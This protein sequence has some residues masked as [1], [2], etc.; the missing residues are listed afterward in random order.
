MAVVEKDYKGGCETLNLNGTLSSGAGTLAA[1]TTPS[2]NWP[3][4]STLPFVIT[5]DRG[6]ATEEI[7]LC[8]ARA[9]ANITIT[10]RGYAGS[11]PVGHGD[12]ATIEHTVD[13]VALA[14]FMHAAAQTTG[15]VTTAEDILVATASGA[16][17]RV[18]KG[19]DGTIL[20][21][22][23]GA[24]GWG[25]IPD[26]S[27]S[28]STMFG[29][30]VVGATQLAGNSVVAGKVAA[31]GVSAANQVANAILTD[32]QVAPANKDGAAGTASLRTLGTGASQAAP[33]ND[34]RFGDVA[35]IGSIMLW[36]MAAAPTR[37]LLLDGSN[38]SRATFAALFA[39]WGTN[40]GAG[41]GSTTFGIPDCRG[42]VMVGLDNMGTPAGGRSSRRGHHEWLR[43][44]GH[45][46]PRHHR[47]PGP[48]SRHRPRPRLGEHQHRREPSAL[49]EHRFRELR[50][51]G[52]RH[53]RRRAQRGAD[54]QRRRPR[55][56]V[57]HARLLG[58]VG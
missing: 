12:N 32:T 26:G 49:H 57:R 41:D 13:A 33:G 43:W 10:T 38:Q 7:M 25:V 44:L 15:K 8:S 16:F 50:Y 31:G 36:A 53:Q 45:A 29:T 18:A 23:G 20:R 54:C 56:H 14:D 42:R 46:S 19:A 39:L 52:S 22:A 34:S 27:I 37:W 24:V 58:D 40:F 30:G 35:P 11:A 17:K 5:V 2:G 3:T 4:G 48:H 28:S 47:P 1:K 55:P 21:V 51:R 6:N 9:G